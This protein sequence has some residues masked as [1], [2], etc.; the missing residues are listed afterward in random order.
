[1]YLLRFIMLCALFAPVITSMA[2]LPVV[3]EGKSNYSII[4][5]AIASHYETLAAKDLQQYIQQATGVLLPVKTD[6]SPIQQNEF[7]IGKGNRH[8]LKINFKLPGFT[9]EDGYIIETQ[10]KIV[11]IA[12][13]TSL[14]TYYASATFLENYLGIRWYSSST[15]IV[16]SQKS[17]IL[18]YIKLKEEPVLT[19]REVFYNDYFYASQKDSLFTRRLKLNGSHNLPPHEKTWGP[20]WSHSFYYYINPG[21]YFATN[22]DYFSMVKGKRVHKVSYGTVELDAQL[23]LSNKAMQAEFI[24]NL[25]VEMEKNPNAQNWS[26][27]QMDGHLG[28]CQCNNCEEINKREGTQMGSVLDFV[29]TVAAS[30]PDKTISTLAYTYTR[31]PPAQ[32]RPAKNVS[33]VLCN[34]ESP[35]IDAAKPV[36]T[37][38]EHAAYRKD[39][40]GWAR[41]TSNLIIW[42]YVIQFERLASPYPNFFSFQP[43]LQY[44]L[45]N[46]ANGIFWQGNREQ[47]GEFA[48]LRGY[49]LAKLA[50]NPNVNV[51]AIM[52]KFLLDYYGAANTYINDYI[53]LSTKKLLESGIRLSMDESP[54]RH[55]KGYMS[56]ASCAQYLKLFEKAENVVKEYPVYLK[57]VQAA[58]LPLLFAMLELGYG[59][60]TQQQQYAT[61]FFKGAA[62]VGLTKLHE[63]HMSTDEFKT[64]LEK[65]WKE[66]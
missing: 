34:I 14:A 35:R 7:I 41:L 59:S 43:N 38:K 45:K 23:C 58:K 49:V 11:I 28:A 27:S 17:W 51:E 33:I 1:M 60:V 48:E 24:K 64:R 30:F 19:M 61:I 32:L 5:P 56:E 16:P 26:L 31:K 8:L 52:Q 65:R 21:K 9:T 66:Q 15:T 37:A 62:E 22:P 39:M 44:Y 6:D 54:D 46:G 13:A 50:W 12:G 36:A 57:R 63:V 47:W 25:G 2:N 3:R 4:I 10:K 18:P 55:Q 40:E 42:D 20:A 53:E 29:N